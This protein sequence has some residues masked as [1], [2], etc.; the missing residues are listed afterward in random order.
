MK[1]KFILA[2]ALALSSA[3]PVH[4]QVSSSDQKPRIVS[5]GNVRVMNGGIVGTN[6]TQAERDIEQ[7]EQVV[8]LT[9]EQKKQIKD[10]YDA[11]DKE[12]K[13]YQA[14]ITEKIQKQQAAMQEAAQSKNQE[15]MRA[16][17]QA[18]TELF[19][20]QQ[21]IVKRGQEA[22]KNVL[23]PDQKEKVQ[24]HKFKTT[25]SAYAPG[26][27]LTE[28]QLN[29]LKISCT[30]GSG[31]LEGYE[32][33]LFELLNKTLTAEQA[34]TVLKSRVNQ[35]LT[36]N[37]RNAN[38]APEQ[39]KKIDAR[40]DA[41]LEGH[42][43]TLHLDG[44]VFQKLREYVNEL[45]TP[46]QKEEMKKP[47]F[48]VLGAPGAFAFAA[49][50]SGAAEAIEIRSAIAQPISAP[51]GAVQV[52]V[53]ETGGE[54][55]A[56]AERTQRG[57]AVKLQSQMAELSKQAV[58]TH[59]N[60]IREKV[61]RQRE[62]SKQAKKLLKQIDELGPKDQEKSQELWSRLDAI[63]AR[64][65]QTLGGAGGFGGAV[66][67][68]GGIANAGAVVSGSMTAGPNAGVWETRTYHLTSEDIAGMNNRPQM[69]IS[70]QPAQP[71]PQFGAKQVVE[72]IRQTPQHQF[73]VA[74]SPETMK[75][76][77]DLQKQ[78]EQLRTEVRKLN[79]AKK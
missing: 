38:I 79:E 36:A 4:A 8:K 76:I 74:P 46:E 63:Q 56:A 7:Y 39:Q 61:E 6:Q 33:L 22:L 25:I 2:A 5:G 72:P 69:Q 21:E 47:R 42:P 24:E 15:A 1:R 54:G 59:R 58:A 3:V 73:T 23:T 49:A 13:D 44:V 18:F 51:V 11:R 62:L 65:Q 31:E 67:G 30:T 27:E 28:G 37:F 35:M 70:V 32:G 53:S 17:S 19:K 14:S 77:A 12:L 60:A 48:S 34:K 20:P 55:G 50:E 9:E 64:L 45:L 57:H 43:K 40:I 68:G 41:M 52:F 10:I 78:I 29:L 16:A 66:F 75:A 26:V 71:T